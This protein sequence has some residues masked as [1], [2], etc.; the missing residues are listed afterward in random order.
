MNLIRENS[1]E[2]VLDLAGLG[3]GPFNLSLAALADSL[4]DHTVQFFDRK[5]SFSWHPGLMLPGAHMQTSY[6][7]DLVTPVNPTSPWSFLSYL[8]QH[9]R[10]YQ[11]LAT[12]KTAISRKEFVDYMSWTAD[13]LPSLQFNSE[14]R[15][16]S[17]ADNCF[18]LHSDHKTIRAR[19]L[20]LGTGKVPHVPECT[21]KHLGK[22]CFHASELSARS[23][24]LTGKKLAVVGGGQTGSEV[25][26][27]ALQGHW[28]EVSDVQWISRRPN[29]EPLDE[30]PFTNQFFT[31]G[32]VDSFYSISASKKPAIVNRQKL[33]SDGITPAYLIELY[34]ELYDR[35]YLS[36]SRQPVWGL[37]PDRTLEGLNQ[38]VNGCYE[39]ILNNTLHDQQERIQTDIVIL[40]TG[41]ENKLPQCMEPLLP[42]LQLDESNRYQLTSNFKIQWQGPEDRKIYAVNAG[43][44]SHGI[45]EP[46]LSL[47]AWRS[48]RILNDLAGEE[49]F[50][51]NDSGS[52]INWQPAPDKFAENSCLP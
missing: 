29:F 5:P 37:L 10:F 51:I 9:G 26:L 45:A 31:P 28:G 2:N 34:R 15:E 25:F 4:P 13:H 39:L 38:S 8:V 36:D 46:Q 6:L 18:I 17:F 27:N 52:I 3:I 24:D 14:I 50:Q 40:C 12:E 47:A 30:T 33:A 35:T 43:L 7:K 20:C 21:R 32:Y 42:A 22:N 19:N 49:L 11:F 48:A 1:Q 23:P 16:V 44:H 41:F